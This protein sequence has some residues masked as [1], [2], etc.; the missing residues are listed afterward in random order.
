[1]MLE[2]NKSVTFLPVSVGVMGVAVT[3]TVLITEVS[4]SWTLGRSVNSDTDRA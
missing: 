2:D 4:W 1:M 3:S